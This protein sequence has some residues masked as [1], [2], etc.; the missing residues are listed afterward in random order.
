MSAEVL[1]KVRIGVTLEAA[2]DAILATATLGGFAE[3]L[4]GHGSA[5]LS[6]HTGHDRGLPD[7]TAELAVARAIRDLYHEILESIHERVDRS[8]GDI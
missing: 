4:R 7:F 5:P 3:P 2:D 6:R 1:P 8:I